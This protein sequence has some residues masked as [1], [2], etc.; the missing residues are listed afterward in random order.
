MKVL[1]IFRSVQGEGSF[2][3]VP[4]TFIR[5]FGCNLKCD[6]CDTKES[7]VEHCGHKV[8]DLQIGDIIAA[9][10]GLASGGLV[11]ITGGE[12]CIQERLGELADQLSVRGYFVAIETNGTLPTPEGINWVVASPKAAAS[13]KINSGC[14][15]NELKYVVTPTFNVDEAIPETIRQ[16]YAGKIWLQPEGSDMQA[17]WKKCYEIAMADPRLRVGIQLHKLMEV[18]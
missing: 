18:R 10:N 1:E 16:L 4:C 14:K 11:V 2:I 7:W 12:P 3:G 13:Y 8:Q 9:V 17:M 15:I 5:L 6:F